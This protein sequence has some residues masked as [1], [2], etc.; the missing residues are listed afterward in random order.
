MDFLGINTEEP[1]KKM[2]KASLPEI[3]AVVVIHSKYWIEAWRRITQPR[4]LPRTL[5]QCPAGGFDEGP[6]G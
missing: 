2:P 5:V 3:E 6:P 1:M 4:A